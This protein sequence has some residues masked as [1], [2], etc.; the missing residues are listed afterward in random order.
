MTISS[1]KKHALSSALAVALLLPLQAA[2][3]SDYFLEIDGVKGEVSGKGLGGSIELLSWSWGA[4]SPSGKSVCAQGLTVSKNED[5]T[6]DDL[7]NALNTGSS[8]SDATLSMVRSGGETQVV[9]HT[10]V[11]RGVKVTSYQSGGAGGGDTP[12]E[13]LSLSYL[14]AE[15]SYFPLE[16]DGTSSE[17]PQTYFL[18]PGKCD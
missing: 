16:P 5:S 2:A 10:I 17:I 14:E 12:T 3:A 18:V 9:N 7:V 13:S 1:H 15:G 4:S 8:F 6:T 11:F